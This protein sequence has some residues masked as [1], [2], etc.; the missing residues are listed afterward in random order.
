MVH[1][2]QCRSQ[3]IADPRQLRRLRHGFQ[4]PLP[5]HGVNLIPQHPHA[6][7]SIQQHVG[8]RHGHVVVQT[9]IVTVQVRR[10]GSPQ[11]ASSVECRQSSPLPGLPID[12]VDFDCGFPHEQHIQAVVEV[13]V[14][15]QHR[16][17]IVHLGQLRSG[18]FVTHADRRRKIRFRTFVRFVKPLTEIV[19]DVFHQIAFHPPQVDLGWNQRHHHIGNQP[20]LQNGLVPVALLDSGLAIVQCLQ[21]VELP[22]FLNVLAV[23]RQLRTRP[24]DRL[25]NIAVMI[26]GL[27]QQPFLNQP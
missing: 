4:R 5:G 3:H 12:S 1:I 10:A 20:G 11:S 23:G 22:G 6:R 2:H 19:Q 21:N 26:Q 13:E 24:F 9:H 8:I 14:E 18:Q 25:Q 16:A 17:G 15:Q 7:R 27:N